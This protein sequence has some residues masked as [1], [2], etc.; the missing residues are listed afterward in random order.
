M[1]AA[2]A[3]IEQTNNYQSPPIGP[4]S[5]GVASRRRSTKRSAKA[6]S[7]IGDDSFERADPSEIGQSARNNDPGM[8]DDRDD[9]DFSDDESVSMP[10]KE[11]VVRTSVPKI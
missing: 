8:D 4:S 2:A 9:L 3:T 5:Q 7:A 11:M 1:E 6:T 10:I